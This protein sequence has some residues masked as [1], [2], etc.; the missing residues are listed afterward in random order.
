MSARCE[1]TIEEMEN[2]IERLRMEMLHYEKEL[3]KAKE[4]KRCED[5]K[6]VI[7]LVDE[8]NEAISKIRSFGFSIDLED[9]GRRDNKEVLSLE[10]DETY[11]TINIKEF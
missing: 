6:T 3:E 2:E 11:R 1:N 10:Y 9:C 4:E 7:N 8:I 5:F